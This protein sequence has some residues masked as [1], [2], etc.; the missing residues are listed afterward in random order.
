MRFSETLKARAVVKAQK[1]SDDHPQIILQIIGESRRAN[2]CKTPWIVFDKMI[3]GVGWGKTDQFLFDWYIQLMKRAKRT[4]QTEPR[5][6][7]PWAFTAI[8]VAIDELCDPD[9]S[10]I[11]ETT[12]LSE[13][14]RLRQDMMYG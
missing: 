8:E 6:Y 13:L 10:E 14:K 12:L 2:L 11:D 4:G 1:K 3:H 5:H 7:V 9:Y